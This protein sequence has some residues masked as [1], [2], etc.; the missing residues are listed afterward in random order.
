MLFTIFLSRCLIGDLKLF[1]SADGRFLRVS[2][3]DLGIPAQ[4]KIGFPRLGVRHGFLPMFERWVL[5][6]NIFEGFDPGSERTLAAW[7][8]HAS[9]TK[10]VV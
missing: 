10:T 7:I 6:A 1:K 9:R 2:F 3:V 8:R 5:K 4:A